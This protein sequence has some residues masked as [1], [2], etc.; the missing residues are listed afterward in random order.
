[1]NICDGAGATYVDPNMKLRRNG[2]Y[3]LVF[4]HFW[5]PRRT[6]DD[7]NSNF[8]GLTF[9]YSNDGI[10]WKLF[11]EKTR[12]KPNV[13]SVFRDPTIKPDP[14]NGGF[15]LVWTSDWRGA[16]FGT[17]W[18]K[19]L[20]F[21]EDVK[22]V[23]IMKSVEPLNTWAPKLQWNEAEENW[24]IIFT[25]SM[26]HGKEPFIGNRFWFTKT[27]DFKEFAPPILLF[28]W[29]FSVNDISMYKLPD[30]RYAMF[31]KNL[32]HHD[33]R[34]SFAPSLF[35]PWYPSNNPLTPDG[36]FSEGPTVINID[37]CYHLYFDRS[38]DHF[39]GCVKSQILIQDRWDDIT[40]ELNL[41][42]QVKH[43]SVFPVSPD[44]A[45]M[46]KDVN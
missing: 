13:G 35:G 29:G 41:P 2:E 24:V 46:L 27:S 28:D 25:S 17:A 33:I 5:G 40:S 23:D 8:F 30:S 44:H 4:S 38:A 34:L 6:N 19:D 31:Y 3:H 37:G 45:Q 32:L 16:R 21:W 7:R 43:G 12:F 39:M 15:R 10:S 26:I 14:V 1:M 42:K 20:L 18:S 22:L 36:V 11:P 9:H